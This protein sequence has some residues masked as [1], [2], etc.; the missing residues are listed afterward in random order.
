MMKNILSKSIRWSICILLII[1]VAF[2]MIVQANSMPKYIWGGGGV[3]ETTLL[4]EE[5]PIVVTNELLTFNLQE[6]PKDY[7]EKGNEFNSYSGELTAEYSFYNPTDE[8]VRAT[9]AFPVGKRPEYYGIPEETG[10]LWWE[11]EITVNGET[12]DKNIRCTYFTDYDEFDAYEQR[13]KLQDGY[14]KDSFYRE[15]LPVT[16]YVFRVEA[17]GTEI[18]NL[19][20]QITVNTANEKTK[21]AVNGYRRSWD[22]ETKTS[23]IELYMEGHL[24]TIFVLGEDTFN[25]KWS[26]Y[27]WEN[28]KEVEGNAELLK[29]EMLNFEE[30]ALMNYPE[31]TVCTKNDWYNA[32]IAYLK[33]C[34][35]EKGVIEDFSLEYGSE[36]YSYYLM[37][38]NEYEISLEPGETIVNK[39]TAPIYPSINMEYKP[40]VYEYM[41]L[42]SPAKLWG[43]F[44][45]LKIVINTPFYLTDSS[46][47]GF[48]KTEAGYELM[49]KGLPEEEL[50]FSLSEVKNPR[51]DPDIIWYE[52]TLIIYALGL[53]LLM[54]A[55]IVLLFW[56]ARRSREK[57]K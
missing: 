3:N 11:K 15:N 47:K 37:Y 12:V 39:V 28:E 53:P 13:E 20:A 4:E 38:W 33:E 52:I 26:F 31:D 10:E 34:E 5:C 24:T 40:F 50:E 30:F 9:L 49:M 43:D 46:E 57:E 51:I 36:Y 16:K 27:D 56:L 2:P 1:A 55:L 32:Q 54:V 48:K 35:P 8:K 19:E 22:G 29:K 45:E 21:I 41:Y 44:G 42:T 23:E 17:P 6:F 7:Y 18:G 25:P 14:I